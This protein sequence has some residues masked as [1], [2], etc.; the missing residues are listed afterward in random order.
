GGVGLGVGVGVLFG[1]VGFGL[2][3]GV[4]F[5][6]GV[7]GGVLV[8]FGVFFWLVVVGLAA[9]VAFAVAVV[10]FFRAFGFLVTTCPTSLG[11][12]FLV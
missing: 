9:L 10:S 8:V 3:V 6:V 5:G 4:F 12:R 7:F 11:F 1:G 2:G